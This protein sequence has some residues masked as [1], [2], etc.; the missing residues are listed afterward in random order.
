MGRR[1]SPKARWLLA[2]TRVG[3]KLHDDAAVSHEERRR[4]GARDA[5]EVWIEENVACSGVK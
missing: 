3:V 2:G 1:G 5:V 4:R